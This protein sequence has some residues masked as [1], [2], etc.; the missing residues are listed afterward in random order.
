MYRINTA[1]GEIFFP[2]G[3]SLKTPYE[4]PSYLVYAEW[5]NQGN[6]PENFFEEIPIP[7]PTEIMRYQFKIALLNAGYLTTVESHMETHI[8]ASGIV[9]KDLD[10]FARNSSIVEEI[11]VLLN[12]TSAQMDALFRDA[13][14]ITA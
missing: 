6:S 7:G 5:V 10:F 4:D 9:W 12:I 14:M 8:G 1:N 11:R 3:T 13:V 2:D